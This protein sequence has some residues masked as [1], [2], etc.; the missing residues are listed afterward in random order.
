MAPDII[1]KIWT[2]GNNGDSNVGLYQSCLGFSLLRTITQAFSATITMIWNP[3]AN[4]A[5][6]LTG[7]VRMQIPIATPVRIIDHCGVPNR[8]LVS[9]NE[10]GRRQSLAMPNKNLDAAS[11]PESAPEIIVKNAN[12][13]IAI[14]IS[15]DA[16][17]STKAN[18]GS[19]LGSPSEVSHHSPSM[20]PIM[21]NVTTT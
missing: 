6:S 12:N 7:N 1:P 21:M 3:D 16:T 10:S 8:W 9:L 18:I 15:V 2:N 11:N 17:A 20:A 14:P 4:F 19:S 5:T 13:A